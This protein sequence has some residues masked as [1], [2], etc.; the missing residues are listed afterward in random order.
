MDYQRLVK[1]LRIKLILSQQEFANLLNVS[2]AS[3]N[4]WE[5]GKHEPTIKAKRKIVE[6]C[7]INGINLEEENNG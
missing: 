5:S 2:F 3:I 4:R 6:L 1:K 7:K